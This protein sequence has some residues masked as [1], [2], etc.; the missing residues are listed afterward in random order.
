MPGPSGA[1]GRPAIENLLSIYLNDH[2]AGAIVGVELAKRAAGSNAGTPMGE[3]LRSL[4]QEIEEDRGELE[5]L[6]S[7]LGI[8]RSPLKSSL[9]W[10]AEKGGRLKLNGRVLGYSDLSRLEELEGLRLGVEGKL[11]LWRALERIASSTD[12]ISPAD[13]ERLIKRAEDQRDRLETLRLSAA[14]QAFT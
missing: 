9:A 3:A 11:S 10:V 14:E 6:M 2:L 5:A 4:A 8:K 1:K 13:L 12:E 7:R